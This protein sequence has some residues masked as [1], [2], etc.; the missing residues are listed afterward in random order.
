MFSFNSNPENNSVSRYG[1][2]QIQEKT[3]RE[4]LEANEIFYKESLLIIIFN[5]LLIFNIFLISILLLMLTNVLTKQTAGKLE[6]Y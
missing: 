6:N 5:F 4:M 3:Y 2:G 1:R